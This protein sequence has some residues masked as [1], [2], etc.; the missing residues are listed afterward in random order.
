TSDTCEI[1]VWE[2][3]Q[4]SFRHF[5][6]LSIRAV[7][8][9]HTFLPPSGLEINRFS[10]VLEAPS[11]SHF[12]TVNV[13]SLNF[14]K[15]LIV[16]SGDFYSYIYE[17]TA[18]SNQSDFIPSSGELIF[19]PGDKEVVVAINIFDDTIPEEEEFFQVWL[20]NPKGGAE[21]GAN[22]Y[23]TITIPSNDDAHGIVAFAQ[24]SLFKQFEEMEQDTL[25]TLN[26]E[27]LI[28][29]YGRVTVQW[30][31]NGSVSDIFP[32]SG[33]ITFSEGQALSTVT[34]T[35][36]S[37]VIPEVA[38]R[39]IIT[40]TQV[41][42]VGI[43]DP[44]RGAIIDPKRAKAV[45]T[46]LPNDSPH[47]IVGWHMDSLSVQV[48]EPEEKSMIVTL[49]ILREQGF[50]GDIS[51]Q[52]IPKPIFSLPFVNQ[53]M[54]NEDY[55][56]ESKTVIVAANMTMASVTLAI[57]PDTIP[58]LQEGFVINISSVQLLDSSLTGGQPS[59]KRTGLEIAEIMIEENDDPRGI[60]HFN[61]T[62][63]VSG[64]V[65]GYE[66]PSPENIL[67]LPVVRKAGK[68]GSIQL[69]WEA[70][71][72]TASLD[73]FMPSFGNLTFTDGQETGM[74]E[75]TI[76][77]DDIVE[78]IEMFSVTLLGV[79]GG[80]RL[81]DDVLV[82]V[83]IP[84]ND[85]PVGVFGFKEKFVTVKE[86]QLTGDPGANA[87]LTKEFAEISG[88]LTMRD[89]QSAAVVPIQALDDSLP[90]EK[91]QYQFHLTG[92][93]DEGIINESA[94]TADITLA[95]S[96]LPHGCFAFS[97]ELLQIAEEEK[98]A[99]ITVVRS[100]GHYGK[101][102]IRY[103]VLNGTAVEGM[104]F[105]VMLGELT[106]EPNETMKTIF[107][108]IHDDDIPEGPED[109]S[110]E[111]TQ[112]ELLGS[113][114]AEGIIEFDP[115]YT[116]L[117]V[118]EDVGL[119][120]IPVLRRRGNY[121]YVTADFISRSVSALPDGV[122]YRITNNSITFHHG[123]NQSFINVLVIDDDEREYDEQFE[124][125]LVGASGGAVL[126][127]HLV[128]QITITK[129]DSPHGTVRFLNESRI[130]LPNPNVS[131]TLSL[132][133]ERTGGLVGDTQV[134]WNILGPNSEVVLPALNS[135]IGDPVN[136]YFYFEEGEEGLRSINLEIYPP[137]D[138]EVQETYIITLNVVKGETELDPKAAS[139]TL[140][141][142]KFGDPNGIVQF[143]PESL[144][145]KY[146]E[147]P[148]E[149]EGPLNI[150]LFVMRIQGT[151]GN[152]TV[153]WEL[154]S[155]S[156]TTDDF[157]ITSSSVII[158]D[159]QRTTEMVIPLLPDDVPEI[160]EDYVV[161]LTSVEG[162]ADVDWE[163]STSRFT[164]FANDEPHG[165][166]ALYS[167]KQS[168]LV[169][170]DLSRHIQIN[171]TRHA[172]TFADVIVEYQISSSSQEQLI[173]PVNTVGH[174][175][176]KEGSS[177]G[178]K[179]VPI[180]P[181][182]AFDSLLLQVRNITTGLTQALI[183]R[184]GVY[185]SVTV[186]WTSGYP[187]GA[188]P[189]FLRP[190]N[191]TPAFGTVIFSHGEPSRAIAFHV[192]PNP[193]SPEAFAVH[194]SEV[195]SNVSGGVRLRSGF[196]IAEIEPMG[197]FQ[198]APNSRHISV[199]EDVQVVRLYV[200]RLLGYQSNFTKVLYQT[201]AGIAKPLEDFESV[202]NGELVFG[203]FQTEAVFE[204]LIIDDSIS[205]G[206]EMFFVNLTSVEVLATQE[207]DL[208]WNPRLNP[209]FSVASVIL[210]GNDI[211]HGILSIGPAV[212]YTEEDSN[213]SI[214]NS[215]LIHIKRTQGFVGNVSVAIKT[216]GGINAQSG[217]G[218]SPFETVSWVS[219]LT[220]AIEGVDFEELTLSVML[221]DGEGE[222]QVSVRI[223]DDDEPEGQEFFYVILSDPEGGAVIMEGNDEYG[224]AGFAT[225]VI[226][227]NDLQNGILG[228][229]GEAQS[230][231]VLDED[232]EKREVQLIVSRQPNR[233]FEDVKILWR[234]TFNET[235]V[236]LQKDGVN[237]ANELVAVLGVV[238]CNA[239]QTKCTISIEIKPDNV[240]EFETSFF[241]E[242]YDVSAGAALNDSS[243]FAYIF[244][245]ESDSPRGLIYFAV[246]SRLA[247]AHKKTT[248]ISL[249]VVR[250]SSTALSISFGYTTQELTRPEAVG[251]I[252][253]SPAISGQDFTRSDG[254]LFFEPGQRTTVL[255]I[256]LTPETGSLNPFPKRFQ[257]LLFNPTGGARVDDIYGIANITIVSDS[258]AQA[259]WGLADQLYQP[260]DDTI[261]N[262]VLQL[263]NV[264]VVLESTE[265]QLAAVM[266]IINKV[267][268][269]VEKHPLTDTNRNLLYEILCALINPKRKDTQGYSFLA[270]ITE[271]FAFSLPI[272]EMC[273][274]LGERGKTILNHCPYIVI[275][276]HSWYPQQINGHIF[277]GKD[278]DFIRI[279]E[280]LLEISDS[281]H[282]KDETCW[283]IQFTEYSSQQWFVTGD[284]GTAL[285][286]K[287]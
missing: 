215:V 54:E 131:L 46:I 270:D 217:I 56:L 143:T 123:Q 114:N 211:H 258:N 82:A 222:S 34:L 117:Q 110:V 80:A 278:G 64:T 68:F 118:E 99:N 23:V 25:I 276:A 165:V 145:P 40:L 172:G 146:Y 106:F 253:I 175:L 88:T 83:T 148:S 4:S 279:P 219:N 193:S 261:L 183:T 159:Q 22:G 238:I 233:A 284:K 161:R 176:V 267:I 125:H 262:R 119:I 32:T 242:L 184:D 189:E 45:L 66:V 177:Y 198:F 135:D 70:T 121:G 190:G 156:D 185:G 37:D 157:L 9:I 153:H 214:P 103:Q 286:N 26:I 182:V 132:V 74:I 224:F 30:V 249:Q 124:I 228:F 24:N 277:Y 100:Y 134:N 55:R 280:R 47:G 191:I 139:I 49:H 243:R 256:M 58:E 152:I 209:E 154:S 97:Q 266:Y 281:P 51:V 142:Q 213:N 75:I 130:I 84:P 76:I 16:L 27:R 112:V 78:F 122:D 61:A 167:E 204:I 81:G 86:P 59:V 180:H 239:N 207:F 89:R 111:I 218:T 94:S 151:T 19:E 181:Q 73:D 39:V 210:V 48:A 259:V 263:L 3:G 244:I 248:L 42:T 196:T 202:H 250:D 234:V 107:T 115:L 231:L 138:V 28:G 200:Q 133:L 240:P 271:K 140:I 43:Q 33:V 11:A 92:I 220:W 275:M 187:L 90:E 72:A 173:I 113:D 102:R 8:E 174:L 155:D 254:T 257:V 77:D 235:S 192:T 87:F 126:G 237:L 18:V 35:V 206:D 212:T 29:T 147:E 247:V 283:F 208:T 2:T 21:I 129:S 203:P 96:D 269:E 53:A 15:T 251:R 93:S 221:L 201:T 273:G 50:V 205:E 137:E 158:L 255:D 7:N 245:P 179:T 57:L 186:I 10:P 85:S 98:W 171:V 260:I 268:S 149:S 232:S 91:H 226:K 166:F 141:I 95:A 199:Q 62:K 109:F 104:D 162:G 168:V 36:L 69:H 163:K 20:K 41:S 170:E 188:V 282:S 178:V 264:K 6:S 136:G 128:S 79:T 241:V 227:G 13:G 105:A 246:G 164:V 60:F 120:M 272:G 230:G 65:I 223:L 236:I 31:A 14:N 225:I 285:K 252:T 17:L 44:K 116:S 169:E 52:L 216:F 5:Q 38:E 63:D 67:K 160:D 71:P 274:S 150:V 127:L 194:L 101:V 287:V 197:I 195:H 265:E 144:S 12:T 108:E 229:T 1:F